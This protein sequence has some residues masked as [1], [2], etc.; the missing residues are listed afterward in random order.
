ML[1]VSGIFLCKLMWV[2]NMVLGVVK[3][4]LVLMRRFVVFCSAVIF[5]RLG[6]GGGMWFGVFLKWFGVIYDASLY[7][8]FV[9]IKNVF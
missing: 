9:I 8:W 3:R 7:I 4:C 6:G 1:N 5:G 2:F